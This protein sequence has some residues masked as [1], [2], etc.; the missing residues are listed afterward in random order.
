M[1]G[2]GISVHFANNG[3]TWKDTNVT[4]VYLNY[5]TMMLIRIILVTLFNKAEGS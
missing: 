4:M 1:K 2:L 3:I 5:S